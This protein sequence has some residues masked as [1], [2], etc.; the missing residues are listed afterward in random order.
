MFPNKLVT[1]DVFDAEWPVVSFVVWSVSFWAAALSGAAGTLF[2]SPY[3]SCS[4]GIVQ[5]T[6]GCGA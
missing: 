2:T 3:N 4:R 6:R 1:R 5:P